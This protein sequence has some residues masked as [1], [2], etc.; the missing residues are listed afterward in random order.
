MATRSD[1]AGI[2]P[3][4]FSP[5]QHRYAL[6]ADQLPAHDH[7][8][9]LDVGGYR[10]RRR[11]LEQRLGR[12]LARYVSVNPGPAWYDA[13]Q[14]DCIATG[15]A[16]PFRSRSFP[17]V[18]CVDSLEHV[19]AEDRPALVND[20]VRVASQRVIVVTP[21]SGGT[22]EDEEVFLMVGETLGVNPMP[23]LAEHVKFGLPSYEDIAALAM[24][25]SG[26]IRFA[27]PRRLYW[28]MQT[29]MLVN[30]A[31]LGADAVAI[32]RRLYQFQEAV[33]AQQ[34]GALQL[35]DAYRVVFTI[36]VAAM[37]ES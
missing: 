9:V 37:G 11:W 10:S 21:I 19:A 34:T 8:S 22:V 32:N 16:L 31:A 36:D 5:V 1:V 17:F 20:L 15:I 35:S 27:S 13:E 29:A 30:T 6:A 2:A 28:A 14:L 23:S 33:L 7:V 3:Q 24:R 12:P 18:V 4:V 26:T 25:H